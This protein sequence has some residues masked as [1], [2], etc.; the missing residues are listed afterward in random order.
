[1]RAA[2]SARRALCF[3]CFGDLA[4]RSR[5][6]GTVLTICI[7]TVDGCVF[8]PA[9]FIE[10]LGAEPVQEF[11]RVG[12]RGPRPESR[13]GPRGNWNPPDRPPQ[14]PARDRLLLF[15][16]CR[17]RPAMS[18]KFAMGLSRPSKPPLRYP[19]V[20]ACVN[21]YRV[22]DFRTAAVR[23]GSGLKGR[24]VRRCARVPYSAHSG[25][26]AAAHEVRDQAYRC[27]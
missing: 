2:A 14:L 16:R 21:V 25:T 12:E 9:R 13:V 19:G 8:C 20:K 26:A 6:P 17:G 5:C 18:F 11:K 3:A 4:S 24:A 1:M 23:P 7:D 27:P 22:R 15:L 10:T